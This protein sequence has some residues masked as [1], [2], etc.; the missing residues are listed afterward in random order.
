MG[1]VRAAPC[2][3]GHIRRS[4]IERETSH[5]TRTHSLFPHEHCMYISPPLAPLHSAD[6]TTTCRPIYVRTYPSFYLPVVRLLVLLP[7][8]LLRYNLQRNDNM[9]IVLHFGHLCNRHTLTRSHTMYGT[10]SHS[11]PPSMRN[12]SIQMEKYC[13]RCRST[14]ASPYCCS[15][16][17]YLA[18]SA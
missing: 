12:R 10:R 14:C 6:Y 5:E 17:I 7:S 1:L 4:A 2:T 3:S 15:F 16:N 8:L 13:S 9:K 18:L 11:K